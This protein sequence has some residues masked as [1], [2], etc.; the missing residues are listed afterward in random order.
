[1]LILVAAAPLLAAD[2][3]AGRQ[4]AKP[5]NACH[6]KDGIGT[7]PLFPNLAGQ[8]ALYLEKQLRAFRDGARR[9]EVMTIVVK[10]LTDK[11]IENLAAY[12]ESLPPAGSAE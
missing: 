3:E 8:K 11:D 10:T 2:I 9:S 1:M 5:C 4:T 7:M 12:Y 6:G